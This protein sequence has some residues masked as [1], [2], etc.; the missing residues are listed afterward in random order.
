M[1]SGLVKVLGQAHP[2][3]FSV[4]DFDFTYEGQGTKFLF[5]D[6][7]RKFYLPKNSIG[8]VKDG[9]DSQYISKAMVAEMKTIG[10]ER[11][12]ADTRGVRAKIGEL[13]RE[14]VQKARKL[15]S[16]KDLTKAEV[17]ESFRLLSDII[18]EYF[19]FDYSYWDG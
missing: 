14:S 3:A 11:T 19:Y 18:R 15:V 6:L 9:R 1:T 12:S 17:L 13:C 5:E 4:R 16:K 2:Q 7:V 10:E 8:I